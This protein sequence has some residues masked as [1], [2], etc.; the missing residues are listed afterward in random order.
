MEHLED[1]PAPDAVHTPTAAELLVELG[2]TD[3]I[4]VDVPPTWV[5]QELT[6]AQRTAFAR[7]VLHSAS[8]GLGT[9]ENMALLLFKLALQPGLPSQGAGFLV[10]SAAEAYAA[11][12]LN[13]QRRGL[14]A[15]DMASVLGLV[16]QTEGDLEGA[17]QAEDEDQDA[18]VPHGVGA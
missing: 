1:Q 2:I 14:A 10:F 16:R 15:L 9:L 7:L 11:Y 13:R 8:Q 4:S 5:T 12:V 17:V 6:G 18:G 3:D